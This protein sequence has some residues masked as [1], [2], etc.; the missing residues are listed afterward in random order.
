MA[1]VVTEAC[2]RCKY[3]DCVA[4]CPVDCFYEGPNMLA[5]NPEECI[6]CGACETEC[7]AEAIYLEDDL[8]DG[9][10]HFAD[11]NRE[12]TVDEKWPNISER[13]DSMPDADEWA[14]KSDKEQYLER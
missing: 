14:K 4:V 13:K 3:T 10:A 8:P 6:D 7:P 11:I 1:Y 12:V 5:I 2:I 9:Q